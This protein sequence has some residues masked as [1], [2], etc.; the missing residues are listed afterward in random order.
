MFAALGAFL[1][2]RLPDLTHGH[3][4]GADIVIF[5]C[6]MAL[7]L[8][9]IFKEVSLLGLKFKAYVKEAKKEIKDEI[10]KLQ[11]DLRNAVDVRANVS[12]QFVFPAPPPDQALPQL[13]EMIKATIDRALAQRGGSPALLQDQAVAPLDETTA[14]L[15]SIRRELEIQLRRIAEGRGVAPARPAAGVQLLRRLTEAQV[16]EPALANAVREVYAICSPAVHGESVSDAQVG[17]VRDVGPRLVATL[18]GLK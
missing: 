9:P 17:F 11:V 10:A 8:V 18:Q 15:V 12:P 7:G 3:A 16:I 1:V 13:E 2:W 5:L 14:F 4:V 6:W